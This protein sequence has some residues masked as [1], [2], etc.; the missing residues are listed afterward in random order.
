MNINSVSNY[1]PNFKGLYV[2]TKD[3]GAIAKKQSASLEKKLAYN[4]D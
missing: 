2:E 4:Y 1:S 3:M